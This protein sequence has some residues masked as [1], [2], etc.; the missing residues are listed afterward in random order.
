MSIRVVNLNKLISYDAPGIFRRID[1]ELDAQLPQYPETNERLVGCL[2]F[3]SQ[4]GSQTNEP[5]SQDEAAKRR[6]FLRAALSEF[7]SLDEAAK[8]DL[9]GTDRNHP[10]ILSS[11]DPR[12]HIV[13]LLRHANVHLA[14]SKVHRKSKPAIW[15]DQEFDFQVFYATDLNASIRA[16]DQATK[17]HPDDL[18]KMID[19]IETEQMEWGLDHLILKTAEVYIR[20]LL[21]NQT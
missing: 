10:R 2:S 16:T 17:Y 6:K 13:R 14:T 4:M 7:A 11:D 9:A 8:L 21:Q 12:L 5:A 18:S 15:A 20:E 19:W 1:P 3:C